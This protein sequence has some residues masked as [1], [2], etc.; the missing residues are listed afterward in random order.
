MSGLSL[1]SCGIGNYSSMNRCQCL[2][3]VSYVLKHETSIHFLPSSSAPPS[4]A[5][6]IP[7]SAPV[8]RE[9]LTHAEIL[10]G[11]QH[12]CSWKVTQ[13]V[14]SDMET[15]ASRSIEVQTTVHNVTLLYCCTIQCHSSTPSVTLSSAQPLRE[16]HDRY[17]RQHHGGARKTRRKIMAL[18]RKT[19]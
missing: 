11:Y 2:Y 15:S 14:T 9:H 12:R 6:P 19:L 18:S 5:L 4:A 10:I 8:C 7:D 13:T 3:Q 16:A 1:A 17:R